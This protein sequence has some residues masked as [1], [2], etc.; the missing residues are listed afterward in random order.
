MKGKTILIAAGLG[1][2]VLL[3]LVVGAVAATGMGEG[4]M[5]MDMSGMMDHCRAM[6][7]RY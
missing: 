4:M 5:G 3:V 1:L 6:M 2:V 7:A